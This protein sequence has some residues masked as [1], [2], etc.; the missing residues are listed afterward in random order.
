MYEPVI[1]PHF[2]KQLKSYVKKYPLLKEGF[3][4]CLKKFQ[5][6][7]AISLGNNVYKVRLS[8]KD[9]R[10][11]KSNSFRLIVLLVEVE[12]FIVPIT[13]YFKGDQADILKKELND[14]LEIVLFELR[15]ENLLQ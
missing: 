4:L 2:K 8:S 5:K 3:I 13:I 15:A 11:G 9:I 1:L 12:H 6:E 14:Q 7:T 10:R